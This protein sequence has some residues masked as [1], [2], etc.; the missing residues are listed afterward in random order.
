MIGWLNIIFITFLAILSVID[1]KTQRIPAI[2]T[3][4]ILF[5]LAFINFQYIS[6]GIL[7]FLFAW[8]LYEGEFIGGIADVKLITCIGLMITNLYFLGIA[9]IIIMVYGVAY[10]VIWKVIL[11]RKGIN[12]EDMEVPFIPAIFFSYIAIYLVGLAI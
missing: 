11:K 8:I 2:F 3:T 12:D 1:W 10:K 7:A 9:F 6:F 4:G 5:M